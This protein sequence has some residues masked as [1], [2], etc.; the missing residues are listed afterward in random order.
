MLIDQ[1]DAHSP[2][3][4]V[5]SFSM[6]K[7]VVSVCAVTVTYGKR[8]HLVRQVLTALLK[9]PA[10]H[11]IVVVSNGVQW[12]VQTFAAELGVDKIEVVNLQSNQGSAIGFAAGIKR[13][14]ELGTDFIWLLDDDNEPQEGAL[15][16]LLAVYVHLADTLAN[17]NM[18]VIAHRCTRPTGP[19]TGVPPSRLRRRPSSF[20]NFHAFDIPYKLW[21]RSP[22]WRPYPIEE[23]PPLIEAQSGPYGGLLFHN[24]V[25]KRHGLPR[26]DFVLYGDDT[27]FTHR[28]TRNGGIIR[29]VTGAKVV[30]L[31]PSWHF[32]KRFSNSFRGYLQ[33]G[34]DT[35]LFYGTRNQTYLDSHCLPH[36]RL[37]FWINRQVYCLGLLFFALSLRRFDRYCLLQKAIRD[38]LEGRMGVHPE[39]PL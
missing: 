28:I 8:Q 4:S 36:R 23:L 38:G 1:A 22:W 21:R 33:G 5:V 7:E 19:G 14:C 32:V 24:A 18:A 13:A 27:E 12:D 10:I 3:R 26:K 37:M 2:Q 20:G 34:N 29:L 25:I 31:E 16:E 9:E 39:Y 11:K 30:D 6:S 15:G 35:R 17:D